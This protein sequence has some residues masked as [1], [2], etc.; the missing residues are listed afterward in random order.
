MLA[1]RPAGGRFQGRLRTEEIDVAVELGTRR[2]PAGTVE[3][4]TAQPLGSLA[5]YLLEPQAEDGLAAWNF[6]DRH[7]AAGALFPVAR[8]AGGSAA[9]EAR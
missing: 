9:P 3:V 4:R 7:L 8:A 6:F 1:V 2:F 5:A